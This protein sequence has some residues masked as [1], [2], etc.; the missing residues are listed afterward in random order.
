MLKVGGGGAKGRVQWDPARDLETSE[1]RGKGTEPRRMLRARAIQIGL[2]R[3]LSATYAASITEVHDVTA[4]ARRVGAAHKRRTRQGGDGRA[5]RRAAARA[6]TC[7]AS[8]RRSSRGS[9]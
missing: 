2:S 9:A 4:L 3:E 6:L 7:R 8:R 1:G 5:P